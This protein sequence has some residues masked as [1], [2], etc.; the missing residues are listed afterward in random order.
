MEGVEGGQPEPSTTAWWQAADGKWYPPQDGR[1]YGSLSYRGQ[2]G[3]P[4]AGT[5]GPAPAAWSLPP[6][7]IVDPRST[8]ASLARIFGPVL[9]AVVLLVLAAN[10]TSSG[11]IGVL[12]AMAILAVILAIEVPWLLGRQ[13]DRLDQ[14]LRNMPQG[15]IYNGRAT[16]VSGAG[17]GGRPV[18]GILFLGSG[19]FSFTRKGEAAPSVVIR[20]DDVERVQLGPHSRGVGA[21]RLV[22]YGSGGNSWSFTIQSYKRLAEILRSHAH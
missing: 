12:I 2:P 19:G 6:C 18:G 3:Q 22:I 20:W 11:I 9:A 21:G 5:V 14:D 10:H 13:Q 16:M 15:G 1:D 7:D 4:P 17:K 8:W